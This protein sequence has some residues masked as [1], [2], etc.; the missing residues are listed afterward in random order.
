L[1][2]LAIGGVGEEALFV[3]M[4]WNAL[5]VSMGDGGG[6]GFFFLEVVSILKQTSIYQLSIPDK[7]AGVFFSGSGDV[8]GRTFKRR[9][10]L[11]FYLYGI[12]TL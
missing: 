3:L 6:G 2:G 4:E 11:R 9:W 12:K 1:D 10:M 8:L 5:D 7:L